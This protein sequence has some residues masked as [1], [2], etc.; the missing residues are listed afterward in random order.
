MEILMQILAAAQGD[1][2]RHVVSCK[3]PET[4]HLLVEASVNVLQE[5][6]IQWIRCCDH[7]P[8][9]MGP[10]FEVQPHV[11]DVQGFVD[12][13][14]CILDSIDVPSEYGLYHARRKVR[15]TSSPDFQFRQETDVLNVSQR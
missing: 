13:N 4:A 14:L 10:A 3:V 2:E 12:I 5:L 6:E 8:F 15:R 7:K 11:S 1:Q 9:G